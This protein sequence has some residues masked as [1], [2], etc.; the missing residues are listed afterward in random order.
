MSQPPEYDRQYDFTSF[1]SLN[2]STPLPAVSVDT[3]FNAVKT[4]LDATLS[5]LAIIQRDD[6]ALSNDIVGMDAIAP[7]VLALLGGAE[8]WGT[9]T[10]YIV[11]DLAINNNG[12]YR[13]IVAHTSGTFATDLAA[14]KWEAVIDYNADVLKATSTTSLTIGTGAKTLTVATSL[15]FTAGSYV[16]VVS[17]ANSSNSMFGTVTSYSASSLIIDVTVI[18]GS[19]TYADWVVRISGARGASGADGTVN[20]ST[21]TVASPDALADS[22]IFYDASAAANRRALGADMMGLVTNTMT[23]ETVPIATADYIPIYDTSATAGRKMLMSDVLKGVKDLTA[24]ASPDTAADYVLTYDASASAAK[25]VLVSDIRGSSSVGGLIPI[26]TVTVSSPVSSVDFVNGSGGVVLDS[27]YKAYMVI[28]SG[29]VPSSDGVDLWLRTSTNAGSSY[30]SGASN[31]RHGTSAIE[32]QDTPTTLLGG[33]S[34]DG[35]IK[36]TNSRQLGS[37]TGESF[38]CVL[39]IFAPSG[40]KY[41]I[42]G[43]DAYYHSSNGVLS[44]LRGSG[45][46]LAAADVDA[47]RFLMS[48]GNIASGTFTLYGLKDA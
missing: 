32:A 11:G 37:D 15:Y 6:G 28:I 36:I 9:L 31:Y 5:N 26:K 34:A 7:E 25:K 1:Q 14:G 43:W 38:H 23:A 18:S 12:L 8:V 16:T 33:D 2:P 44:T 19:G 17:A 24:D 42:A 29:I 47:I 21:L 39:Y 35:Q 22:F 40:T 20:I 45:S 48:S 27:T 30:D 46:R 10:S 3:E 13:C 4:T 41:T